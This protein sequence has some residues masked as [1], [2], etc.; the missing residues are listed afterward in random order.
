[1]AMALSAA[2]AQAGEINIDF[3]AVSPG[4]T[5]TYDLNF[6]LN[7]T[8]YINA[9]VNQAAP[10]GTDPNAMQSYGPIPSRALPAP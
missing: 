7:T 4:S 8:D 6:T 1:M 5:F 3:V 10:T 2:T 9:H